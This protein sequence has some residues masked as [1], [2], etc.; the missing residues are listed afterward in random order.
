MAFEFLNFMAYYFKE[1]KNPISGESLTQKE[2]E[3]LLKVFEVSGTYFSQRANYKNC[4]HQLEEL[5]NFIVVPLLSSEHDILRYRACSVIEAFGPL[6][7]EQND[8]Y[9]SIC[10]GLCSNM[11]HEKLAIQVKAVLAL[12]YF[13]MNDTVKKCSAE[14]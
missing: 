8:T 7:Y 5:I 10:F 13:L 2:T 14:T 1:Q 6:P 9:S 3:Y 12:D 11:Q 4:L